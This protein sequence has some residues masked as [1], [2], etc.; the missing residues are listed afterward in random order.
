MAI[1]PQKSDGKGS[2]KQLQVL[3]NDHPE[4]L[5]QKI[6][7]QLVQIN[8]KSIEWVSPLKNDQYAEYTDGDFIERIGL[9]KEEINLKEF[10]P[11]GGANWDGLAKTDSGEIILVEAKANIPE[12]VSDPSGAG[13]VSLKKIKESLS[14]TKEFLKIKKDVDWSGTFYQYTNRVA[15]L[16]FL[17]EL[18][19]IEAYL[20]NIYFIGDES[21]EGPKT[22]EE[23]KGA[24]KVMQLYLGL[25]SHKLKKYM[26]DVFIDIND[27]E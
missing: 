2:L 17:R 26:V 1:K 27:L 6:T 15:H 22:V 10:W 3:I 7:E 14:D 5:N 9:N 4:L 12:M 18:R 19:N 13:D 8:R 11:S 21:V 20:V 24:I 16:Y 25:H 23:W